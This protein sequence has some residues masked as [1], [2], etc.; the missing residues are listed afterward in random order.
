MATRRRGPDEVP[1]PS[2]PRV[3][4]DGVPG[5]GRADRPGPRRI[6]DWPASERPRERLLRQGAPALADAELLAIL[7]RTGRGGETAVDVAR[8]VL[9]LCGPEGLA[10][11]D[12]VGLPELGGVPGV[13]PAKAA[14]LLAALEIGRRVASRGTGGR[15]RYGGPGDVAPRLLAEM[16]V[17]DREQFR[18]LMLDA[19]HGLIGMEVVGLGGLSHVPAEPREVFKPAIRW[20]AAAVIVAH[21]HPSG[22]PEPSPMDRELTARLA[23]AG[24]LLGIPLLDH[25]VIGHGRYVSLAARGFMPPAGP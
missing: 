4:P 24:V 22:D 3:P 19:K 14:V 15:P 18:V 9:A 10:R 1:S 11:L 12:A 2:E 16:G 25:L 13:G 17:L 20:S 8:R 6:P 5:P 23:R 21:N 7:L